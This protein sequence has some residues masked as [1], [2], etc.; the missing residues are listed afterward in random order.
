MSGDIYVEMQIFHKNLLHR[1]N[2]TI[3]NILTDLNS[4]HSGSENIYLYINPDYVHNSNYSTQNMKGMTR[5]HRVTTNKSIK[6]IS[7]GAV[8]VYKLY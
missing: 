4:T 2:N 1:Y 8:V 3:R 6:F 7:N 5:S